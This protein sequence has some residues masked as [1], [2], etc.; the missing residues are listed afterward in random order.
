[1]A[2]ESPRK[3][4]TDLQRG[5]AYPFRARRVLYAHP[6]LL[7]YIAIPFSINLVLFSAAVFLGLNLFNDVVSRRIPQGE[8]WYWLLFY[9]LFWVLAVVFTAILVFFF[10]TAL[11]NLIASPFN[12]VLSERTEELITGKKQEIPFSLRM[13]TRD[14]WRT[15][16]EEA[17]KIGI[18]V[19][20]MAA[21]LFLNLLPGLGTLLYSLF[22]FFFILF[23]L[24]VEYTGYVF[25][26]KRLSFADQRRFILAHKLLTLGFGAGVL[27]M[28]AIPFL[29]F[30][31]IPLA[32]IGATELCIDAQVKSTKH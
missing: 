5:F 9:Y 26:R 19:L 27:T 1:M 24:V 32:V 17:R 28:L 22:S 12:D 8:A 13:L 16:R 25:S 3:P 30:L 15:V 10:F 7:R 11:G 31:S 29:Q 6:R 2:D 21:L 20:G 4:L 14:A 23:F 18:F